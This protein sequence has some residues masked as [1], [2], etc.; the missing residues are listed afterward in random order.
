MDG[1]TGAED[2]IAKIIQDP[3]LLK[4]LAAQAAPGDSSDSE[5]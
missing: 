5:E 2:L 4:T 3:S 1:K